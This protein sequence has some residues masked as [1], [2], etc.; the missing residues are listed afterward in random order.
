[1]KCEFTNY[2][3]LKILPFSFGFYHLSYIRISFVIR[4][5]ELFGF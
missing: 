5:Y 2:N 3:K 4:T 1:M